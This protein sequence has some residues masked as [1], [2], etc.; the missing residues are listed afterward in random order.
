MGPR[1]HA[2]TPSQANNTVELRMAL[3]RGIDA[4]EP[5]DTIMVSNGVY[6]SGGRTANGGSLTNRVV[7]DRVDHDSERAARAGALTIVDDET[8]TIARGLAVVVL[9]SN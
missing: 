3:N 1:E 5:G 8:K 6:A 7:I 9:I 4:S 2:A